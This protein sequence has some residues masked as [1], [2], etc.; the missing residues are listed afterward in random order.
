MEENNFKVKLSDM[1]TVFDNR[2]LRYRIN[3]FAHACKMEDVEVIK[4]IAINKPYWLNSGVYEE[5]R[6]NSAVVFST[7]GNKRTC[8]G[9]NYFIAVN[10]KDKGEF[11]KNITLTGHYN[12][13]S[14]SF[15]NYYEKQKNDHKVHELPFKISLAKLIENDNYL[16]DIETVNGIEKR[17]TFSKYREHKKRTISYKHTFYVNIQDFSKV[18]K[19]VKAFVYNPSLVFA[20]YNEIME[21][22]KMVLTGNDFDKAIMQDKQLDEPVGKVKKIVRKVV[23]Y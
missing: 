11:G 21:N 8:E 6:V 18:L 15:V 4:N 2:T 9:P 3:G 12:D 17:V 7:K 5:H 13:L 10:K 19:L 20:T 1:D 22:K 23:S 16:L 14:F